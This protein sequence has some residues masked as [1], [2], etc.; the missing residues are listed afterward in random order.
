[1][2]G[3]PVAWDS[4]WAAERQA[5]DQ[6]ILHRPGNLH[7]NHRAL[8]QFAGEQHQPVNLR[9]IAVRTPHR[10]A[11]ALALDQHL[12]RPAHLGLVEGQ[13]NLLLEGH[14]PVIAVGSN[15]RRHGVG[16]IGCRRPLLRG[17]EKDP[18]PLK[19]DLGHKVEH[20]LELRLGLA[21]VADDKDG[22]Q[23][24]VGHGRPQVGDQ[25]PDAVY[26]RGT[27][28]AAQDGRMSMLQRQVEVVAYPLIAGHDLDQARADMAGIGV[29]QPQPVQ[30][31]L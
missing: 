9:G 26:I 6:V 11:V 7:R 20:S 8:R 10:Q 2:P 28:H 24:Q 21:R 14:Q 27:L 4:F 18:H 22:A 13:R 1:M 3:A 19:A 23:R 30:P 31:R 29:H 15:L 25:P 5:T 17:I 16:Q 12:Q